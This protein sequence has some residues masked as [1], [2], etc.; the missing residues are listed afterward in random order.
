MYAKGLYELLLFLIYTNDSLTLHR[1][2]QR[3]GAVLLCRS[4]TTLQQFY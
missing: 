2:D 3:R 1:E 4:T